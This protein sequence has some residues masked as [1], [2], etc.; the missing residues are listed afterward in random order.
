MTRIVIAEDEAI[1][2]MDL[3]ELLEV[4]GYEVVGEC[5]RGDDAV[6]MIRS[7]RP[8]AAVLDVKMPGLDGIAAA[9]ALHA[10]AICPIVLLTAFSQR[11]LVES[12][13]EVGVMAY[14]VKPF[15]RTDLVPAIEMAI[16]RFRDLGDARQSVAS[17]EEQLRLRKLLDRAKAMLQNTYGLSE[18]DA[19]TF[20]QRGAMDRRIAMAQVA[21][22]VLNETLKP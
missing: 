12:A 6:E 19:F 7:L 11:E 16:G 21:E 17:L 2:R 22:E 20:I 13:R 10:E 14:V 18:A 15:E 3:R 1:I 4:E 5:A 9:S 8:D